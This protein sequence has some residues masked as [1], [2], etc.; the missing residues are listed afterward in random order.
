MIFKKAA[1]HAAEAF[2]DWFM[3]RLRMP[4]RWAS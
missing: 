1:R 2:I 3:A 4:A